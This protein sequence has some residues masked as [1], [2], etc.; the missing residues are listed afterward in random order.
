MNAKAQFSAYSFKDLCVTL[1]A[2]IFAVV[3]AGCAGAGTKTGEVVD[4]SAITTKVKTAFATDKT[5][6]AINVHVDTEKGNV[7]LSGT[8][9]SDMEKQRASEIARSVAGVKSVSNNLVVRSEGSAGSG[10]RSY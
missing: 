9:K 6:S 10:S 1:M 8:V 5:V 3:L 7:R 4:D 2:A